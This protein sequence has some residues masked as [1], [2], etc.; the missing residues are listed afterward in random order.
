MQQDGTETQLFEVAHQVWPDGQVHWRVAQSYR[1]GQSTGM[2]THEEV[3]AHQAVPV[4]KVKQIPALVVS[5]TAVGDRHAS[6]PGWAPG[7]LRG[8]DTPSGDAVKVLRAGSGDV[9]AFAV[10]R[11]PNR[12]GNQSLAVPAVIPCGT[13][14]RHIDTNRP[15]GTPGLVWL[16]D[17]Q[18]SD[19]IVAGGAGGGDVDAVVVSLAPGS[20][21]VESYAIAAVIPGGAAGRDLHAPGQGLAPG[22][23]GRTFTTPSLAVEVMGAV[24]GQRVARIGSRAPPPADFE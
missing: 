1:F 16:A 24:C 14:G 2:F 18:A 10:G 3:A 21:R 5:L 23:A 9:G 4:L 6:G 22:L 19:A 17:A 15:S 7:L 8:A 20:S 11:A 12:P 13:A